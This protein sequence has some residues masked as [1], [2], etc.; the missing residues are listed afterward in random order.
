[1]NKMK[2][3]VT[4]WARN[5]N[6]K[7]KK[8]KHIKQLEDLAK[9][10]S[11]EEIKALDNSDHKN[12]TIK[13]LNYFQCHR[14]APS[15]KQ[16]CQVRDYLITY[17][18]L[19]NASRSGGVANMTMEEY[20]A[21]EL[22]PDGSSIISIKDHKT[23]ATSGPAM[24]CVTESYLH[25][26][27]IFVEQMRNDVTD[28]T[29]AAI[30]PVFASW[31]GRKMAP[32]MI[33]AQMNAFWKAALGVDMEKRLTATIVRKMTT[34]AV[35]ENAPSLKKD[36]ANLMNH[37]VRTAEQSYFLQEKKKGVTATSAQ[38]R[39]IIRGNGVVS[40]DVISEIFATENNISVDT[41]RKYIT[42]H[43]ELASFPEKRLLDKVIFHV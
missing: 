40:D 42:L 2:S 9:L 36:L 4:Q 27:T 39:E 41:I 3:I 11:P 33:T 6:T 35:H 25:H 5:F 8:G 31:S 12:D 24:L 32:S 14:S 43:P 17:A 30:D 23:A 13:I 10:P 1:M 21:V 15:R 26:L 28:M 34:T 38:V 22:Q 37:N 7:I 29:Y 19:D 16:Y 20:E 18:I